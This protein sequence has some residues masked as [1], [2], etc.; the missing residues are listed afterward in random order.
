MSMEDQGNHHD[1]ANCEEK[2][3]QPILVQTFCGIQK[4]S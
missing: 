2:V 4:G 1:I 3:L